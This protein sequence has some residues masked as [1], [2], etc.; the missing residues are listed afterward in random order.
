MVATYAAEAAHSPLKVNII[1][2]GVVRT[3]MRKDAF[4]AEDPETLPPPESV[5]ERFIELAAPTCA[6]TGELIAA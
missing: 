3:G 4:P 1:D 5:V 6:K 2:P